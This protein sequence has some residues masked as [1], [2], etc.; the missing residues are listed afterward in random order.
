MQTL[1]LLEQ[2]LTW[3]FYLLIALQTLLT[4]IR[5]KSIFFQ[6]HNRNSFNQIAHNKWLKPLKIVYAISWVLFLFGLPN[7]LF[8]TSTFRYI[9]PTYVTTIIW[10][11][12][13]FL[14]LTEL[15]GCFTI[16]HSLLHKKLRQVTLIL[17]V[18][19]LG[20]N[21]VK[22]M[23]I[24]TQ[25]FNYPSSKQSIILNL[26][27]KGTWTA[28][29][30]GGSLLTNE[31]SA[32]QSQ[33]YAID[34]VKLDPQERFFHGAGDVPEDHEALGALVY[35]PTSG[36]VV[37]IVDSLPN[38]PITLNPTSEEHLPGNHVIIEIA[39]ERYLML[40][41]LKE[42]SVVVKPGD[43][44]RPGDLI[45]TVGNSGTPS[46]PHLHLQI[47]DLPYIDHEKATGFPLRFS[48]MER[49]RWF[50]WQQVNNGFILRNDVF[51][52]VSD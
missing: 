17:L 25:I 38:L 48:A 30:A 15:I 36:K 50:K 47:Q 16:S 13:M 29:H 39:P 7:A 31:H 12:F 45:A 19:L 26:P 42:R 28:L 3:T 37:A 35:A 4:L 40:S 11:S 46:W 51:R 20:Y 32:F 10:A 8:I 9:I 14:G 27:I 41:N 22:Q 44:L 24:G 49:K 18:L 5:I 2:S 6:R 23:K 34:I 43:M 21:A 52:S 33:R 1:G